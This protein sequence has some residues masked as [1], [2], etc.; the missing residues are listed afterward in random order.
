MTPEPVLK[1]LGIKFRFH[2][3]EIARKEASI[4]HGQSRVWAKH[5]LAGC[6]RKLIRGGRSQRLHRGLVV[7]ERE[8]PLHDGPTPPRQAR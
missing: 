7:S 4:E 3:I 6:R 5:E 1:E 8:R 2:M